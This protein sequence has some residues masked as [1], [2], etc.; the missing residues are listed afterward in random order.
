MGLRSF[1]PIFTKLTLFLILSS[2]LVTFA[3]ADDPTNQSV[4]TYIIHSEPY[5]PYQ[6]WIV[7][8]ALGLTFLILALLLSKEQ[9]ADA[10]SALSIIPL[11]AAAWMA[12]QIDIPVSGMIPLTSG[13]MIRTE[14]HIYPATILALIIVLLAFIAI[15]QTYRLLT[16][17][18]GIPTR[19]QGSSRYEGEEPEEERPY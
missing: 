19:T 1:N 5:T 4:N 8:L 2:L 18:T 15:F 17:D 12:L 9:N 7:T 6:I 3:C 10:F 11:F 14:H 13:N 16:S